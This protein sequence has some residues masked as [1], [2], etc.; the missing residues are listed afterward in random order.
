M[1]YL[2]EEGRNQCINTALFHGDDDNVK[3]KNYQFVQAHG[4]LST[5]GTAKDSLTH[6]CERFASPGQTL[7]YLLFAR[8]KFP[9][10]EMV[11]WSLGLQRVPRRPSLHMSLQTHHFT[12]QQV[13]CLSNRQFSCGPPGRRSTASS[14][15]I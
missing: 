7:Y 6:I 4:K 14:C 3:L 13:R 5:Q 2:A 9:L 8:P 15:V 12:V 11:C 10:T 1:R